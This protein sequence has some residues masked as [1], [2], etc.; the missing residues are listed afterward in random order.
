MLFAGFAKL[1][2]LNPVLQ[3]LFIFCAVVINLFANRTLQLDKIILRHNF[4]KADQVDS[5]FN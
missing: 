2:K 1:A 3:G 4:I 5:Y